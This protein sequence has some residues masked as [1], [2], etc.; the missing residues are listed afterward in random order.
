MVLE[1][2]S[3]YH[4]LPND[5]IKKSFLGYERFNMRCT[6]LL[7]LLYSP[8]YPFD[9]LA[10]VSTIVTR[11]RTVHNVFVTPAA[12]AGVHRIAMLDFTKL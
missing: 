9:S 8:L 10:H 4:A 12:I 5:C 11:S 2:E 6:T 1:L 3:F 7:A